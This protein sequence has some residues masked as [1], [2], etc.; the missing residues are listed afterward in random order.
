MADARVMINPAGF[1][2]AERLDGEG[3]IFLPPSSLG[4]AMDGDEAVVAWWPAERGAEGAVRSVIKRKRTR[5]T[6][7]LRAR[8]RRAWVEPDDPRISGRAEVVGETG[9]RS[10]WDGKIVVGRIVD[11]PDPWNEDFSVTIERCLGE[12]GSLQ[13][14]GAKI[15]VEHGID[16]VLPPE[17]LEA[18]KEVPSRVRRSDHEG[19]ADLRDLEFMTI[20]PP[21]A[22]DFDDAVCVEV[23]GK[24]LGRA[25]MRVHV[26]VA[27]VSHYVRSGDPFDTEA[28]QRC[29]STYLPDR[30][31]SMLPEALSSDICSLVPK[32]DRCAMVVSFDLDP[33]GKVSD[34]KLATALIHSRMRLSYDQVAIELEG[35]RKLPAV[36]RTRIDQLKAASDRLGRARAKR[37]MISLDLPEIKIVLDEDDPERVRGIVQARSTEGMTLAYK[38]IEELM[39]AAN[40]AVGRLAVKHRLPVIYRVHDVPDEERVE[41]LCAVAELLGVDVDPAKLVTSKGF[42]AFVAKVADHPRRGALHSVTLRSLAQAEYSTHNVGH[43]ALASSAYVHFTSPIRRYPDLVSHRVLKAWLAR[44]GGDAGPAPTPRMP[45][46]KLVRAAAEHSSKRER[47]AVGA[48]RDTKALYAAHY[49]RDR[50]GDRFEGTITGLSA[51]GVFVMLDDPPVDGMIKRAAVEKETRQSYQLDE[52]GARMVASKGGRDLMIGDRLIVEVLEASLQRRQI[53]LTLIGVLGT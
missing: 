7:V 53:D 46:I 30:A 20:D 22:R 49:M 48:E 16:P 24:D 39:I 26:A 12:P 11:Y 27:D 37:G 5:I 41:R 38:L 35:T 19:R 25:K 14:E 50:I 6:G 36:V 28:A 2:F 15:L 10:E 40:E 52:L 1:G 51:N 23:K 45:A 3:S 13:T 44:T 17:V 32:K 4:G 42:A 21:S 8:R 34:V 43:F 33:A 31:I 18:A 9:A 29:F 47:S